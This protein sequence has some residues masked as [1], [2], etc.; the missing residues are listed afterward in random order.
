LLGY[1]PRK[2]AQLLAPEIDSG[3]Q[4]EGIVEEVVRDERTIVVLQL[5]ESLG[6]DSSDKSVEGV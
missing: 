4:L 5:R 1:L 3:L 2:E 6:M